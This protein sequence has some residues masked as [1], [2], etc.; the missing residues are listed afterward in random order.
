M[1]WGTRSRTRR[2][3]NLAVRLESSPAQIGS[4]TLLATLSG[5]LLSNLRS[6][7][8]KTW[9][10][11]LQQGWVPCPPGSL[12]SIIA[13]RFPDRATSDVGSR[14]RRSLHR[15]HREHFASLLS[16]TTLDVGKMT[17]GDAPGSTRLIL[18][19]QWVC[20][21][22]EACQ[23][24]PGRAHGPISCPRTATPFAS[25]SVQNSRPV[26]FQPECQTVRI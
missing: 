8:L 14:Y 12:K 10:T 15:E 22:R 19:A 21:P 25:S 11:V 16:R 9:S 23:L 17:R 1:N 20:S 13:Q 24:S 3:E 4:N 18:A 2:F 6:R 5:L 26:G 7:V